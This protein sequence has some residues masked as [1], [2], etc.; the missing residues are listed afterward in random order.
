[1]L[2]GSL[3]Q[4]YDPRKPEPTNY[5]KELVDFLNSRAEFLIEK[6]NAR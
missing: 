1:M 4:Y 3:I 6:V 2:I 5:I